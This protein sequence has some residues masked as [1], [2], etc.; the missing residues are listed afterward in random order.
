[1]MESEGLHWKLVGPSGFEPLTSTMSTWRSNQ[2]S[3]G[4]KDVRIK[5]VALGRRRCERQM[6]G[7]SGFEPLTSTMSTWRSNQLSYGPVPTLSTL[8]PMPH[9]IPMRGR[10]HVQTA[11]P[12]NAAPFYSFLFRMQ[13]LVHPFCAILSR[14]AGRSRSA[15]RAPHPPGARTPVPRHRTMPNRP[16]RRSAAAHG[17]G[18][19]RNRGPD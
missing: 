15:P 7:P 19:G 11:P 2:L 1:M 9:Y 4:P 10:M 6:V 17:R 8:I 18:V 16:C 13:R 5:R 14:S 12:P 3:Y